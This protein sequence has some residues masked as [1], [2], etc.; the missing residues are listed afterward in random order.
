MEFSHTKLFYFLFLKTFEADFS[1]LAVMMVLTLLA[2]VLENCAL[3]PLLVGLHL[4]VDPGHVWPAA[5]DPEADNAHLVPLTFLLTDKRTTSVTL[6]VKNL[7]F[8]IKSIY[9]RGLCY[10]Y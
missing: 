5:A 1:I 4:G 2:F 9:L 8:K 7:E 6:K 3:D 10:T